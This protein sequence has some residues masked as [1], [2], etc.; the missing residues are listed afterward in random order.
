MAKGVQLGHVGLV[1]LVIP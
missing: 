1:N